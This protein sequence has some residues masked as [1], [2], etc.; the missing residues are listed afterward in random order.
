[1][2]TQE[3]YLAPGSYI[4]RSGKIATGGTSQKLMDSNGGRRRVIIENPQS[5]TSQGIG[6]AE[7][8]FINFTLPASSTNGGSIELL[9][10]GSYDSDSGPC[11]VEQ[12]NVVA[13]T[14]G[15]QYMAKEMVIVNQ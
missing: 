5:A 1:M 8:L 2:I 4:D 15:H 6:T 11:T 10:G 9:P 14:T 3:A 7:N 13:A 12:I